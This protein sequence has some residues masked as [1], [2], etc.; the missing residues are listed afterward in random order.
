MPLDRYPRRMN[1]VSARL[2]HP[3]GR[4]VLQV[5]LCI[6]CL[7]VWPVAQ[8]GWPSAK[9]VPLQVLVDPKGQESIESVSAAGRQSDFKRVQGSFA[10]GFSRAVY[11]FRVE[12][13]APESA[14]QALPTVL[15][16]VRPT[17]L[18]DVRFYL[19]DPQWPDSYREHRHGDRR[20]FA[21]RTVA[22]RTLVQPLSF[23]DAAPKVVYVRLQTTSSA[24]LTLQVWRPGDFLVATSAEYGLLGILVGGYLFA[25]IVNLPGAWRRQD[26]LERYFIAYVLAGLMV[27][28]FVQGLGGQFL[29]PNVPVW[30]DHL[31]PIS[32]TLVTLIATAFYRVALGVNRWNRWA[33]G[34]YLGIIT[35]C[36]LSLPAPLLGYYDRVAQWLFASILM[37]LVVGSWRCLQLWREQAPDARL[38]LVAHLVTLIGAVPSV[39]ALLGWVS[40]DFLV[41]YV[42]QAGILGSVLA[43]QLTLRRR[44]QRLQNMLLISQQ[45][46]QRARVAANE[47]QAVAEQ[48]R[49]F[50]DMI[51]HELKT[52]LS[53]IRMRLGLHD[54]SENIQHHARNAVKDMDAVIDRI[55][56]L[57]R[58]EDGMADVRLHACDF[59]KTVEECLASQA[60]WSAR[61]KS[62][63][64]LG[65]QPV[66][67]SDPVLLRTVLGNLIDNACKYSPP[68]S[69]VT[70][71]G[72]E[73]LLNGQAGWQLRICNAVGPAGRPDPAQLFQKYY[74]S[75]GAR[76]HVGSGLGLHVVRHLCLSMGAYLDHEPSDNDIIFTLWLPR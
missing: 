66:V 32:S 14:A 11:W 31:V 15:L 21:E 73:L 56:Q 74:R 9:P 71:E 68:G 47:Q 29:L 1:P 27:L 67:Q 62:S 51:T 30:A 53:V 34:F 36:C 37:M 65:V 40:G 55:A 69:V 28:V 41:V 75:A 33:N 76:Q 38:L 59:Q 39:L 4:W 24:V 49:R 6:L 13:P 22:T 44:N 12:I 60:E 18:D 48:R 63:W 10:G 7:A 50:I 26:P 64:Q 52:P 72:R 58:L 20:A 3:V 23:E 5:C 2:F 16:E 70:L 46:E 57:G 8:A 43:V 45:E 19:P 35:L 25:L 54:P 17:Y 61:C 42:Y